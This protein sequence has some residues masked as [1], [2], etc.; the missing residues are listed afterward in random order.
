MNTQQRQTERVTWTI[1]IT[2]C[3]PDSQW[4]LVAWHRELKPSAVWQP[5]GLGWKGWGREGGS[6]EREHMYTY[7]WCMSMYGRNLR[8]FGLPWWLR[9]KRICL[10]CGSCCFSVVKSCPA[11]CDLMDCSTPAF[12]VLH[13]LPEVVQTHAHWISGAIQ[14]SHP[15][16]PSSPPALNLSQH[17]GLFPWIGTPHQVAK[18]LELQHQSFQWIFR[19]GF[20]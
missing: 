9:Q 12:P 8:R 13:C 4:K 20:L 6:R 16:S 19:V 2:I 5:R 10:Q 1:H 7:G 3:K 18:V 11:L 14:L 15:L 17:Q